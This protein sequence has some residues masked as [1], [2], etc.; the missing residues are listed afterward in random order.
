VANRLNYVLAAAA[1]A[2]ARVQYSSNVLLDGP[3]N[4]N[5]DQ[6]TISEM[7]TDKPDTGVI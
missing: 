6:A 4:A 3:S 5:R 2:A 7:T 1:A